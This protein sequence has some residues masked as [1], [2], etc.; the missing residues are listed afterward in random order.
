MQPGLTSTLLPST[1]G[2]PGPHPA[3]AVTW[4]LKVSEM[5]V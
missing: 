5:G 1:K 3:L 4:M 2:E